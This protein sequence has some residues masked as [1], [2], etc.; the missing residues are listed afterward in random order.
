[1]LLYTLTVNPE[2]IVPNELLIVGPGS[3]KLALP[4]P[5]DLLLYVSNK[6]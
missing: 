2:F 1:M 4:R 3:D 6:G 5:A